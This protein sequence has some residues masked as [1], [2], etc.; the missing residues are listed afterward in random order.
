MAREVFGVTGMDK[1]L[2]MPKQTVA[3]E[4][5]VTA[6]NAAFAALSAGMAEAAETQQAVCRAWAGGG[7][8]GHAT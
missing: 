8:R 6:A 3:N 5:V 1:A 2:R 4:A 7:L